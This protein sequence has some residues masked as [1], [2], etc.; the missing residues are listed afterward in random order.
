MPEEADGL[1]P[2]GRR[3]LRYLLRETERFELPR[4]TPIVRRQRRRPPR[5][6]SLCALLDSLTEAEA[7]LR[8]IASDPETPGRQRYRA[9]RSADAAARAIR[10]AGGTPAIDRP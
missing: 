1:S 4:A 6:P 7:C 8:S 2:R 5:S 9:M 3:L 10:E